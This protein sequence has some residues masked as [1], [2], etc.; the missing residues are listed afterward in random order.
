M[1]PRKT[2]FI[3]PNLFTLGGIFCGLFSLTL[4][5]GEPTPTQ[6]YQA[7]LAIGYGFFFDVAD[8]RV[9]RVTRTQSALGLQLDSLADVITFGVAPAM[10]MYKW[11]LSRLETVTPYIGLVVAFL[12]VAAAALRLA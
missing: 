4:T 8:G 6:L 7:A 3:L 9:A 10:L 11:G 5:M 2:F 12:Y 1:H